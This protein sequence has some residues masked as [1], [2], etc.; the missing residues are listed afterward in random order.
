[1]NKNKHEQIL[2]E[3][4]SF[5]KIN[6]I[7]T[8]EKMRSVIGFFFSL[9]YHISLDDIRKFV[10]KNGLNVNDIIIHDVLDLLVEYGFATEKIFADNITRYEHLHLGEHHDH[11]F[12]LKCGTIIEFMS[13]LIET[14]QIDEAK[15][16][17]FH[18]FT[19]KMQIHGLCEKCFGKSNSQTIPLSMVEAG[20]RFRVVDA[21]ADRSAGLK[22][23]LMDM[24]IAP[25]CEGEMIVN[26]GGRIVIFC[27]GVRTAMGRG[28]SQKVRVTVID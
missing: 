5:L 22:V 19:H 11:L 18:P 7:D 16:H 20:G 9:D 13:P 26:H 3:C 6:G 15:K 25:G 23:H 14:A 24:G 4:L 27:N 2:N 12:C 21:G 28:M 17:G 1:V 8:D 10:K